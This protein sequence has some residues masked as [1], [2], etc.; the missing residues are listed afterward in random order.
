MMLDVLVLMGHYSRVQ[1]ECEPRNDAG[2]DEDW[3]V[4]LLF[5]TCRPPGSNRLCLPRDLANIA[6]DPPVHRP[7]REDQ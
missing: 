6:T 3:S 1:E 7:R 2:D 4:L 5:R